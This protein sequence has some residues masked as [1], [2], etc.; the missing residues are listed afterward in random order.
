VSVPNAEEAGLGNGLKKND[1]ERYGSLHHPGDAFAYDIFTQVARALRTPGSLDPLAGLDAQQVLA[2]GESQSAFT[3]TTYV[4][5]VQPLTQVFDGFLI[6]SRGGSSASLGEPGTGLN[7]VD[8]IIGAPTTIRTDGP[9][10]ILVVQTE[11]DVVGVLHYLPARQPD[12]EHFR[13]WEVAGTA[14]ADR[15]QIGDREDTL[16]CP[17]LIN[18]G[19]QVFVLRTALRE[20]RGWANG[21]AA[22]ATAERLDV[23]E[24]GLVL[25]AL[26]NARGG[27][28]TPVVDAPVDV[29]TGLAPQDAPLICLL[30]GTTLPLTAEQLTELYRSGDDYL[31]RYEAA[32]DAAIEAGFLLI[33]DRSEIL[34]WASPERIAG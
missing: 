4:N 30:S 23:N 8:T 9:A 31:E 5:G 29:L 19:Q 3:L 7:V 25:D 13:L 34:S 10:P 1:P 27:V 21:A 12:D 26:G 17:T 18:R 11:T 32:T 22:P 24:G 20:L 16:G 33:D 2:V 6:H 15:F 14:H 28:R